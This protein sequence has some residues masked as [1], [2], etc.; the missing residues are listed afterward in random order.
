MIDQPMPKY[1]TLKRAIIQNIDDDV[2]KVGAL[3][4]SERELMATYDVSRITVR[5]A[6]D[7]L[8]QAGYLYKVQGKGTYVK[9]DQ[10]KQNLI[11]LTSCTQDILHMGMT[12][13]RKVLKGEVRVADKKRQRKLN[14]KEGDKVFCLSRI[15]YADEEPINYT[16]TYLPYKYFEGIEQYDFGQKSLYDTLEREYG[17][18]ITR[19]E[20]MVEAVIAYDE[21]SELLVVEE[22]VP[23]LLFQSTTY[24]EVNGREYPIETFKCYYR[25][26]KFN[27]YI[28][29]VR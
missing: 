3:I 28:K 14:L 13:S 12:P 27:F 17:T 26:D 9:G 2:Y 18:R 20:R 29:Q 6:V 25:S 5:K 24:G 22:G 1:Y 16:V 15:Y 23:L 21:I 8:E 11:S 19:A 10:N 7:E 4:P